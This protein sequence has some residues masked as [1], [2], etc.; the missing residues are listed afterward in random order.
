MADR[1]TI[2]VAVNGYGVRQARGRCGIQRRASSELALA[3][4]R[5]AG[6]VVQVGLAGGTVHV[7][8]PRRSS[9]KYRCQYGAGATSV[10][11]T[12]SSHWRKAFWPLEKI[13]DG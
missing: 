6:R 9:R 4:T 13:N 2:S 3:S 12:K 1:K 8:A 10:N 7:T 5:P 11:C